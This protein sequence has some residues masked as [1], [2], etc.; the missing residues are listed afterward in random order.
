[1]V[2]LYLYMCAGWLD[3]CSWGCSRQCLG[4][5]CWQER[6]DKQTQL[7]CDDALLQP[8]MHLPRTVTTHCPGGKPSLPAS[9]APLTQIA[10]RKMTN[11]DMGSRALLFHRH[12][13]VLPAA[14]TWLHAT[15]IC[16]HQVLF[17]TV[18][19]GIIIAMQHANL[20]AVYRTKI[21]TIGVLWWHHDSRG[22]CCA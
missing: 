5:H 18:L 4:L 13:T 2:R 3:Q 22:P 6:F 21:R 7:W 14:K 1:M 20:L 17:I 8:I 19:H 15:H 10:Q 12:K 9:T 11:L 16:I